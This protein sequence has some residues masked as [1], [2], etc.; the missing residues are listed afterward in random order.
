MVQTI[1]VVLDQSPRSRTAA[2]L[3]LDWAARFGARVIGYGVLDK[4]ALIRSEPVPLGAAAYKMERDE[5][6]I[7]E[8]HQGLLRG[9]AEFKAWCAEAGV[10]AETLEEMGDP[11]ECVLR[12]AQRCD[13][14][15]VGRETQS[16]AQLSQILRSSP[17]PIVAVPEE[18]TEGT[19]IVVAYGGGR[20]VA[21]TLQTFQLL[22]LAG[23]E[24]VHLVSVRRNNEK[25]QPFAD[26]AAG[27]LR[28][29]GADCEVH[30]AQ[31]DQEPALV[32]LDQVQN[33]HA[34]ILVM[35][36]HGQHPL[37]DL[38]ATSVTRAVLRACPVPVL[39][40]A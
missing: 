17:R 10:T 5:A 16:D 14:V 36:A 30:L 11:T 37:R 35:G 19:G 22:G 2:K 24:K 18:V 13:V 31:S 9:F 27:F 34:R 8:A 28:A 26:L 15:I 23:G 33:L 6:R 32:L 21:R 29:H 1:L 40:G 38:F 12:Q 39:I 3:A 4:R 20:E 7:G 25:P